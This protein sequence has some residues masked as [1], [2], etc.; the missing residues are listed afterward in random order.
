MPSALA[1]RLVVRQ[2]ILDL[3]VRQAEIELEFL[4]GWEI[5]VMTTRACSRVRSRRC[6]DRDRGVPPRRRRAQ[7]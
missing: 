4:S 5:P 6:V 3:A 2:A 1:R 7:R